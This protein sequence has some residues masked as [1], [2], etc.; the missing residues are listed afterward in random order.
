MME[1]TAYGRRLSPFIKGIFFL[2]DLFIAWLM[3]DS[4]RL[5]GSRKAMIHCHFFL[6]LSTPANTVEGLV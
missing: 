1:P 6:A 4:F 2:S 5:G 3:A